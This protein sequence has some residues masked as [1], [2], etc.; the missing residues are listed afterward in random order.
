MAFSKLDLSITATVM[1]CDS[2]IVDI[3]RRGMIIFVAWHGWHHALSN[4]YFIQRLRSNIISLGQLDEYCCQVVIED[5]WLRVQ[6]HLIR[7][8]LA[9]VK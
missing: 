4:T 6:D 1:F 9:K 5:G 8:L 7:E 2:L 3:V